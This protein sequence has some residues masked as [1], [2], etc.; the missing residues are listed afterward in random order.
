MEFRKSV[1]LFAGGF[2]SQDS[3][4]RRFIRIGRISILMALIG[5]KIQLWHR[6]GTRRHGD[7]TRGPVI[8]N[9]KCSS[10]QYQVQ[11]VPQFVLPGISFKMYVTTKPVPYEM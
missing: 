6:H 5:T 10:R 2:A 11:E 7:V 4:K 8:A 1:V 3:I 9:P